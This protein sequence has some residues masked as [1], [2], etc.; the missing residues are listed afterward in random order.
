MAN[1][2]ISVSARLKIYARDNMTCVY[3]N[4]VCK[5]GNTGTCENP[6]D[7]ATL[8][9]IVSQKE[10]A[11]VSSDD[12]DFYARRREANNLVVACQHCNSRKQHKTVY[13]FCTRYNLDY[14]RVV[15]EIARR[16]AIA[17]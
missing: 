8:D 7:C 12:K 1:S 11:S 4:K 9:H 5:R 3:C 15:A 10:L 6:G 17:I 16:I 2:W 13:E 14:S